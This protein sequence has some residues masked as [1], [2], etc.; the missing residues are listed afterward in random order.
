MEIWKHGL[1]VISHEPIC[2]KS[3]CYICASAGIDSPVHF[4]STFDVRLLDNLRQ[5]SNLFLLLCVVVAHLLQCVLR[6]VPLV[7]PGGLREA[8]AQRQPARLGVSGVQVLRDMQTPK[9]RMSIC[10]P[11]CLPIVQLLQKKYSCVVLVVDLS[12]VR[13]LLSRQLLQEVQLSEKGRQKTPDLGT[14]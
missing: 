4:N 9:S 2:L 3:A 14:N 1:C 5:G 10:P 11:V 13:E 7:L 8:A 12:L 6:A